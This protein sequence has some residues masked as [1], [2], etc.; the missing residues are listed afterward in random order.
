M[1]R[2]L[3]PAALSI[4]AVS[5]L[6]LAVP[7]V[8]YAAPAAHGRAA[9]AVTVKKA[10]PAGDVV[11]KTGSMNDLSANPSSPDGFKVGHGTVVP[12]TAADLAAD[13]RGVTYRV[14]RTG[15]HPALVIT[16]R[17]AGPFSR[18]NRTSQSATTYTEDLSF[19]G[20]ETNL[21][22]GYTVQMM[23]L[24][25][26]GNGLFDKRGKRVPCHG[27][28]SA[29]TSGAHVASATVPLSCLESA[30]LKR[31]AMRSL[32]MHAAV[33]VTASISSAPPEFDRK[34]SSP[35]VAETATIGVDSTAKTRRLQLTPLGE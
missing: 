27:F 19:D 2:R 11:V 26:A 23:D 31:S 22:R 21:G 20:L 17:V 24:G 7:G 9:K 4:A 12:A 10:D 34:G 13:L 32:S 5:A 33:H 16:Y 18:F 14:R 35:A 28:E 8:G 25:R 1:R 15:A 29:M 6:A 30:G 3:I